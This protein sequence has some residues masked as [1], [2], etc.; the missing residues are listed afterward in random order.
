MAR[1][2][3]G[4]GRSAD[5]AESHRA[6][7]SLAQEEAHYGYG[8]SSIQQ[9]KGSAGHRGT[10]ACFPP[11]TAKPVSSGLDFTSPHSSSTRPRYKRRRADKVI[12]RGLLKH[13]PTHGFI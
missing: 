9:Y 1:G 10:G 6:G 5:D 3:L 11:V 4:P 13:P 8:F 12:S 7:L 2:R